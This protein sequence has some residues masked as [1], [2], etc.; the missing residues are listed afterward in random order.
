MK[1]SRIIL[2]V[3]FLASP[4]LAALLDFNWVSDPPA[5]AE[6][7]N[8]TDPKLGADGTVAWTTGP[9]K[10][11]TY[12]GSP[13]DF[14]ITTLGLPAGYTEVQSLSVPNSNGYYVVG[15]TIAAPDPACGAWAY[16]SVGWTQ[17]DSGIGVT[18][19][20]TDSNED[21]AL[22]Q[23]QNGYGGVGIVELNGAGAP[24]ITPLPNQVPAEPGQGRISDSGEYVVHSG[25]GW[26]GSRISYG[27][28]WASYRDLGV[29]YLDGLMTYAY[30]VNDSGNAVGYSQKT[31]EERALFY[32]FATEVFSEIPDGPFT[33]KELRPKYINNLNQVVGTV[34]SNE[35]L[36]YYDYAS[37]TTVNLWDKVAGETGVMPQVGPNWINWNAALYLGGINDDGWITGS[38]TGEMPWGGGGPHMNAFLLTKPIGPAHNPGDV[39]DSGLVGGA[40]LT[41]ILT[42]WGQSGMSWG[43][44]DVEPYPNGDG[45]IGGGDYTEVLTYWGTSY[46]PEAI[47]EP[48]GLALLLAGALALMRRSR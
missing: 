46:G 44:G 41:T 36:F 14:T 15:K 27:A 37:N 10:S 25:G 4:A 1:V 9:A 34:N 26:Q 42:N 16:T 18:Y 32:N 12:N 33:G 40:D 13:N 20:V 11:A 45:F 28:G 30:D 23:S 47:P 43:D 6:R 21:Y 48:T 22:I 7:A 39:D 3:L 38:A 17:V 8:V 31:G 2:A 35:D 24:G 29:G 5:P 19:R